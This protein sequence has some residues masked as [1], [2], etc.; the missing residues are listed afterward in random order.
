[1]DEVEVMEVLE[2]ERFE[3]PISSASEAELDP[4]VGY[5]EDIAMDSEFEVLQINFIDKYYQEFEGRE[6]NKLTYTPIFNDYLSL[7]E[8]YIER[9]LLEWIPGFNMAVSTTAL[10]PHKD[11]MAVDIFDG[12]LTFTD[13]LACKEMFLDYR[14]EKEGQGLDLGSGLVVTSLYKSCSVPAMQNKLQH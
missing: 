3:L 9:H 4:V 8:K 13:F 1:M 12:L 7:V 10:K 5:T 11:E 14:A 2:E 6:E